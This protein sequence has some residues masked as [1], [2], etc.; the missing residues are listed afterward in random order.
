MAPSRLGSWLKEAELALVEPLG[1]MITFSFTIEIVEEDREGREGD[2]ITIEI[3]EEDRPRRSR[4][5]PPVITGPGVGWRF[6][7]REV[8]GRLA[9][10]LFVGG[11][12]NHEQN[13]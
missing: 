8:S 11:L 3:A 6:V 1:F 12:F 10:S 5:V 2:L 9:M 7:I 13:M 4:E